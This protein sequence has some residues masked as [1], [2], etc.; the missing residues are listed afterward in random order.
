VLLLSTSSSNRSS[1]PSGLSKP[2]M[3]FALVL[4]Y[5]SQGLESLYPDMEEAMLPKLGNLDM[6]ASCLP[7]LLERGVA[8][9]AC[10]A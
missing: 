9:S 2:E 6:A 4:L 10:K 5:L 8:F 1:P 3:E 7:G